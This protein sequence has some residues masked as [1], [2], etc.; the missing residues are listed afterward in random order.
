[1]SGKNDDSQDRKLFTDAPWDGSRTPGF[2]K[3]PTKSPY[4][5]IHIGVRSMYRLASLA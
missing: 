5:S 3:F 4:L 2:R 1:M